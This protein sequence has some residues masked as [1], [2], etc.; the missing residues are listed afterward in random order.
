MA[1][2]ETVVG[3][4]T[5]FG[6]ILTIMRLNESINTLNVTNHEF[7]VSIE[8]SIKDRRA[9][10]VAIERVAESVKSAHKRI[11]RLEQRHE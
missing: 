5:L 2:W 4:I 7:R 10:N 6:F 11:D 8:E 1:N 3:F 9:L